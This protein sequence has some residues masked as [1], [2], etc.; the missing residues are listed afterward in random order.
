[1]TEVVR[2]KDTRRKLHEKGAW[3]YMVLRH[4][5]ACMRVSL[6]VNKNC[7]LLSANR[8]IK[9]YIPTYVLSVETHPLSSVTRAVLPKA[10]ST[11][12]AK[13]K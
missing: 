4:F 1:M 10:V 11:A 13:R 5:L 9:R 6:Q 7:C 12:G 2:N 8:R 3:K